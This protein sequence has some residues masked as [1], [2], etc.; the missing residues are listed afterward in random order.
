MYLNDSC[1]IICYMHYTGYYIY[2]TKQ[3]A[4]KYLKYIINILGYN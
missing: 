2:L 1:P 4:V 3:S